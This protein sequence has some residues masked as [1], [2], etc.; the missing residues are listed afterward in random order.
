MYIDTRHA[1]ELQQRYLSGDREAIGLLYLE[2]KKM[3][4]AILSDRQSSSID[5]QSHDAATNLITCYIKFPGFAIHN[6]NFRSRMMVECRRVMRRGDNSDKKDRP[7]EKARRG[8]MSYE[9][10]YDNEIMLARVEADETTENILPRALSNIPL[11][12]GVATLPVANFLYGRNEDDPQLLD[13]LTSFFDHF[14][15]YRSA[16]LK[17]STYVGKQWLLDHAVDVKRIFREAHNGKDSNQ[18]PVGRRVKRQGK[19]DD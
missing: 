4:A 11:G 13:G 9:T 7:T 15:S 18:P 12:G 5:E 10:I 6:G 3:A 8:E 14:R 19:E 2:L 1:Q 17:L 16:I